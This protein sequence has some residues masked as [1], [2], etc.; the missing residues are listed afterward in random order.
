MLKPPLCGL[1]NCVS[2]VVKQEGLPQLRQ[3]FLFNNKTHAVAQA[4][5]RRFEQLRESLTSW[6]RQPGIYFVKL[7]GGT[8]AGS[9]LGLLLVLDSFSAVSAAGASASELVSVASSSYTS[10]P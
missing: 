7:A 9:C 5:E 3:A 1:S 10:V 8:W 2:L 4:A 6:L